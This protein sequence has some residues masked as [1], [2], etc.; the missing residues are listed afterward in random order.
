VNHVGLHDDSRSPEPSVVLAADG[1]HAIERDYNLDGVVRVSRHD[2]V[3]TGNEQDPPS[4]RYQRGSLNHRYAVSFN[5]LANN[6]NP[7]LAFFHCSCFIQE[8]QRIR[9]IVH[10]PARD[11][12]WS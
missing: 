9:S 2:A 12:F 1:D 4:Q 5:V 3:G 8:V 11:I 6:P 10:Q 7:L